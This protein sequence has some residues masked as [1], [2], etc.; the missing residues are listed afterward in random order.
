MLCL[1][2]ARHRCSFSLSNL[3]LLREMFLLLRHYAAVDFFR[4]LMA[5]VKDKLQSLIVLVHLLQTGHDVL[6][7]TRSNPYGTIGL[8]HNELLL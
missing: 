7:G 1:A 8:L 4:S 5:M 2:D 3:L 6:L